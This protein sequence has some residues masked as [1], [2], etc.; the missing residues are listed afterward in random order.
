MNSVELW[1]ATLV[2]WGVLALIFFGAVRVMRAWADHEILQQELER[3]KR[4]NQRNQYHKANP[5]PPPRSNPVD[6]QLK[7]DLAQLEFDQ[8]PTYEALRVNYRKL[9]RVKH[10]DAGGD[11]EKFKIFKASY[12]RLEKRLGH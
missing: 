6:V 11:P 9:V 1:F 3:L 8:L 2:L 4:Q 12:D 10:P 5:P 7:N